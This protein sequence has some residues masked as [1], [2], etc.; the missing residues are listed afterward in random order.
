MQDH[1]LEDFGQLCRLLQLRPPA[2]VPKF[3]VTG[4]RSSVSDED[5]RQL[6]GMLRD[7]I[8]L[9]EQLAAR[10][11]ERGKRGCAAAEAK[12]E[13]QFERFRK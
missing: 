9:Y 10:C 5:R 2:E 6:E 12:I 11:V 3:N 13:K 1:L 8:V 7:D 4:K